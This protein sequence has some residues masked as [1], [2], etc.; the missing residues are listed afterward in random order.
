MNQL[1]Y[2][3][4]IGRIFVFIIVIE[5]LFL[6]ELRSLNTQQF[7]YLVPFFRTILPSKICGMDRCGFLFNAG[8]LAAGIDLLLNGPEP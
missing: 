2:P 7:I 8:S 5:E 6:L 4:P 3:H 1:S